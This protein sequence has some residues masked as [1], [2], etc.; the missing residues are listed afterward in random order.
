MDPMS[1]FSGEQT[2]ATAAI[3]K[4]PGRP[5]D[6]LL[7]QRILDAAIEEFLERGPA[8]FTMDGV[9]RRAGV[10]KSTVY[11]RW[12]D[13]DALLVDGVRAR[14]RGIEDVDTGSL[15]GDLIQLATNLLRFLLDP[16]GY[17][18]FRITVDA[19]ANPAYGHVAKELAQRHRQAARRVFDRARER[20]DDIDEAA[21]DSVVECLYGAI[22]MKVLNRGLEQPPVSD[23]EMEARCTTTVD[24]AIRLLQ[25]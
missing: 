1:G 6:P 17:A 14:S 15:R 5:R 19:V 8:R 12:P 3:R 22:A 18:T 10:G 24:L 25:R 9:A 20:G 2:Q 23:A 16:V 11:L 7:E 13:R 4:R 21:V